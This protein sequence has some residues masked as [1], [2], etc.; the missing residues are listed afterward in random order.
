MGYDLRSA[1]FFLI[2]LQGIIRRQW[3]ANPT[4]DVLYSA[5]LLK[6]IQEIVAKK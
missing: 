6:D 2:D 4:T 5:T 1:M 3:L